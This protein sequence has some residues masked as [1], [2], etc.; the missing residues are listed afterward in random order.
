[1]SSGVSRVALID[2]G[3]DISHNRW[4][5][6]VFTTNIPGL[7]RMKAGDLAGHGTACAGIILVKCLAAQIYSVQIFDETLSCESNLL[8][9]A[10]RWSIDNKMCVVNIS[11]G[12][13]DVT[14]H[15][16]LRRVCQ[17]AVE[18][19]LILVA[20]EHNLGLE[21]YPAVF[22][23]VIGVTGAAIHEPDGYYYRPGAGIE[24]VAR[25][26]EQ[27]LCWLGGKHVFLAGNSFAAPHITGLIA[28]WMESE[29]GMTLKD[30]RQ[31]LREN[32]LPEPDAVKP[33]IATGVDAAVSRKD[34]LSWIK[35]AVVYPMNKEMHAMIRYADLLTF[36]VIGVADHVGKGM[37]GKD[38]GKAIGIEE[39]G[40]QVFARIQK[41]MDLDADTLI[42]GYVDQL[43]RIQEK[44][45]IEEYVGLALDKG[46]NVF[47]FLPV[48]KESY[49][50]LHRRAELKGLRISYPDVSVEEA[51]HAIQYPNQYPQVDVPVLAVLGTSSQQGKFTLQ[52]G[53]RKRLIDLGYRVG[54][55]GTEHHSCLFGMDAVFPIGYASPVHLPIRF[56]VPYL[57]H[58]M[59]EINSRDPDLILVGSQ[60]GTIPYDIL[61]HSTHSVT[62]IP[63]LFG[64][65]PDACILVVNSIDPD[66]YV[67]D[68]I[69]A[70]R[71][72]A[73]CKC[74]ALAM[75]DKEKH[76]RQA[77]GK[78]LV[79]VK[80]LASAE[81]QRHISRL[82]RRFGLPVFC[83]ADIADIEQLTDVAVDYFSDSSLPDLVKEEPQS[84]YAAN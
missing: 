76:I 60:S 50:A 63:Y 70:I 29:P 19:G 18:A 79:S 5:A 69:D 52:L 59:R 64:T 74:I 15:D 36:E 84:E 42:L 47:S 38:A 10:I 20:A 27:R 48:R 6:Q 71:S 40:I 16:E 83:I 55:L 11:L 1:M 39:V 35:R 53:L 17:E 45:L 81:V 77:Y 80:S 22:P 82:R 75:S 61:E 66:D 7:K 72:I 58:K 46:L 43:G 14:V 68:T 26:D 51:N 78:S 9:D 12:T 54:Q 8:I 25:G 49:P 24:C 28:R 2:S 21:S 13:T 34:D 31:K 37:V 3:V 65:K 57:D 4:G 73:K 56:Y 44:D 62:S 23:E 32:A 67:Q 41:L 33:A 30:V